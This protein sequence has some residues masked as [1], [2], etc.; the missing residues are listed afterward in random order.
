M[1]KIQEKLKEVEKTPFFTLSK[2]YLDFIGKGTLYNIIYILF[3]VVSLAIPFAFLVLCIREGIFSLPANYIIGFLL[4][5]LVVLFAG[6]VGFQLW[7]D[8]KSKIRDI[9]NS[10]FVA[11]PMVSDIVQT[12]GEWIGTFM[13]IFGVGGGLLLALFGAGDILYTLGIDFAPISLMI[14]GPAS[15][16]ITIIIFRLFAEMMRFIAALANNTKEI[17]A[18]IKNK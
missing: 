13:A 17:A 3:A 16:L 8:R 7:W 15:G 2:P 14:I 4:T 12:F 11:I 1:S 18:N 10:E 9:N 6:W 5:W